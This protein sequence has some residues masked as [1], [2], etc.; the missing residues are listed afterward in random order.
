VPLD[1]HAGNVTFWIFQTAAE[2]EERENSVC[3]RIALNDEAKKR[4]AERGRV[5][6][7]KVRVLVNYEALL[8]IGGNCV[9]LRK[10]LRV[11]VKFSAGRAAIAKNKNNGDEVER[12]WSKSSARTQRDKA[13][14]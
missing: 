4:E 2:T 1:Y 14:P 7:V 10:V 6:R 3:A 12:W 8:P 9:L 13:I 11:R 5:T